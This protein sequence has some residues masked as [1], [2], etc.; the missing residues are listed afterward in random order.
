MVMMKKIKNAILDCAIWIINTI[1]NPFMKAL[2]VLVEREDEVKAKKAPPS[3]PTYFTTT[4]NTSQKVLSI[5]ATTG[6]VGIGTTTVNPY[7]FSSSS[8]QPSPFSVGFSWQGKT[9]TITLENGEDILKLA[10]AMAV[11]MK[12]NNIPFK[13]TES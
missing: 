5:S 3:Q 13:I 10:D 6:N 8:F 2:D 1:G 7:L 9:K 4:T 11:L 12:I